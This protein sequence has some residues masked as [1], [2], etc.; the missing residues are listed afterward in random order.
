MYHAVEEALDL[1]VGQAING[2][3]IIMFT[4]IINSLMQIRTIIIMLIWIINSLIINF[5]ILILVPRT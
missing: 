2:I 3:C 1:A 5:D 4:S